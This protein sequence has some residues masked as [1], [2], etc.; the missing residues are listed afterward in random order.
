M[1]IILFSVAS[2]LF[3]KSSCAQAGLLLGV[4]LQHGGDDDELR[5]VRHAGLPPLLLL[6]RQIP[7]HGHHH[8]RGG[9]SSGT[10]NLEISLRNSGNQVATLVSIT[11]AIFG[12][13]ASNLKVFIL[14]IIISFLFLFIHIDS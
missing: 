5:G 6:H 4:L 14:E 1:T 7:H 13:D 3:P 11:L 2:G 9:P 12:L 8:P 10:A